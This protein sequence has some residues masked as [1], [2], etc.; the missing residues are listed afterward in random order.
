MSTKP[1]AVKVLPLA[2]VAVVET[3]AAP[4]GWNTTWEMR[5]TCQSW[6]AILPPSACTA[7]V[8]FLQAA[9][10]SGVWMPGVSR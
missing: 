1:S 8:T 3:G 6:A 2:G 7:S 9:I 4:S 10:C 5:P